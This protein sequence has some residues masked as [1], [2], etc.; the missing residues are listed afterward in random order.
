MKYLHYDLDFGPHDVAQINLEVPAYVRL[1]DDENYVAYRQGNQ[2]RYHGGVANASPA[3]VKPP[4]PGHWHLIIDLGGKEGEIIAN[5]HIV[6][7]KEDDKK[8]KRLRR[9]S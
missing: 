7:E 2:Y 6:R 4:R 1:T 3:N 8:N 5:V 9:T